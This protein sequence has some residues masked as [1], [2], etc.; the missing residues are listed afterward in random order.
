MLDVRK[1]PSRPR[2]NDN[3]S[4]DF[5]GGNELLSNEEID[6]S[7]DEY[8]D[9]LKSSLEHTSLLEQE[10]DFARTPSK[11]LG[12]DWKHDPFD[13]YKSTCH[14]VAFYLGSTTI[15]HLQ[16][17]R[18]SEQSMRQLRQMLTQNQIGK[19]PAVIISISYKGV[20]FIDVLNNVSVCD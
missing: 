17:L 3:D 10:C 11:P 13:L 18:S 5:S 8:S 20:R 9:I 19:V 6:S 16:G 4:C 12:I 7:K 15:E 14:Y 2:H 1:S